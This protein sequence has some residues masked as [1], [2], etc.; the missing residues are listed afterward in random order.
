VSESAGAASPV[1]FRHSNGT[2]ARWL[3]SW[4]PKTAQS[5][6]GATFATYLNSAPHTEIVSPDN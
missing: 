1:G 3:P 6:N 2:P 5:P 4:D